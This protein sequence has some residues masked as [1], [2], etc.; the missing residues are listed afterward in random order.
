MRRALSGKAKAGDHPIAV[1]FPRFSG[2]KW[3][4]QTAKPID[5]TRRQQQSSLGC[6]NRSGQYVLGLDQFVE[7]TLD[8]FFEE[9][10]QATMGTDTAH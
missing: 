10:T 4:P 1:C 2:R 5:M 9:L 8:L 7:Y 3:G 6:G